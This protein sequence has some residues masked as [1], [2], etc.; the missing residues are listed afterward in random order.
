MNRLKGWLKPNELT[1][2][3]SDYNILIESFGSAGIDRIIAEMVADGME[4]KPETVR[5]IITRFNRKSIDMTL[6]GFN[7]STGLVHLRATVRGVA[8]DK[9]WDPKRNS[10]YISITKGQELRQA[11]AN[12]VVDIMG[13]HPDPMALFGITDLSTGAT[14]G[15]VTRGFN[16][17]I[18]GSYIK[19][20]G[21]DPTCGLYLRNVET[22]QETRIEQRFIAVNDP[23][24]ILFIV[25]PDLPEGTYELRVVTQYTVGAK[26]VKKPR[27]ATLS[28]M[29]EIG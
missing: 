3:P 8:Y 15:T 11:A 26:P 14:D 25:P 1:P 13:V 22:G 9:K 27:S 4:I 17:E 16:A 5:N 12:T 19:I 21:D 24:R 29:L 6:R 18:R 20:A 10:V 7:V 28:W 2:D 23:S